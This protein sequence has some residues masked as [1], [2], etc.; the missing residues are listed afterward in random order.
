ML[1][2]QGRSSNSLSVSARVF[3][4]SLE[5]PSHPETA[6]HQPGGCRLMGRSNRLDL[7]NRE[8]QARPAVQ[9][10]PAVLFVR[11]DHLGHTQVCPAHL[12]SQNSF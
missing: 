6:G 3:L 10:D 9:E 12:G 5:G 7:L 8:A 1:C 4:S 11:P 2:A